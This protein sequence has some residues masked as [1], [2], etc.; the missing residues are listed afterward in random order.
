MILLHLKGVSLKPR[1]HLKKQP[2]V[3]FR[4]FNSMPVKSKETKTK[5]ETAPTC[6]ATAI[7]FLAAQAHLFFAR[8]RVMSSVRIGKASQ[9]VNSCIESLVDQKDV[10]QVG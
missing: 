6:A 10:D 7:S 5:K 3:M 9:A 8:H 4:N 2:Q 1:V